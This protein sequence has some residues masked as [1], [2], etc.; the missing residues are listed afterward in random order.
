MDYASGGSLFDY[1]KA[2]KRLRE[3]VARWFFQQLVFAVD[4]W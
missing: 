4:Y 3:V 2:R 1:V